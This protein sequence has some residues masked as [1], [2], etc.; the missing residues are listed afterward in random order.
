MSFDFWPELCALYALS[1]NHVGVVGFTFSPC[2]LL[3]NC[4][5]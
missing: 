5:L 1:V 3:K 4:S 2:K